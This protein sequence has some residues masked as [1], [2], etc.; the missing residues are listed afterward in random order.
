MVQIT[1]TYI[2]NNIIKQYCSI[3][4]TIKVLTFVQK[5]SLAELIF[6]FQNKSTILKEQVFF[7]SEMFMMPKYQDGKIVNSSKD[8]ILSQ[9]GRWSRIALSFDGLNF[10]NA[11]SLVSQYVLQTLISRAYPSCHNRENSVFH[12]YIYISLQI[13]QPKVSDL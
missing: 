8:G 11:K 10:P 2:S 9:I 4:E 1:M 7:N 5:N 6:F 3:I 13:L 12:T